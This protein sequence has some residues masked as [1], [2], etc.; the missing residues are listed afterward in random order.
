MNI[1][2]PDDVAQGILGALAT[3][4]HPDVRHLVREVRQHLDNRAQTVTAD[5]WALVLMAI[6]LALTRQT[7]DPWFRDWESKIEQLR[8][9]RPKIQK[10]H[11]RQ[12]LRKV[13]AV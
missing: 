12:Q 9:V 10:L 4:T 7:R 8:D 2:I 5:E 3:T 1:K 6:D 11:Q 13:V